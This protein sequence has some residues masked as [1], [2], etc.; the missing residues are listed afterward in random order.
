MPHHLINRIVIAVAHSNDHVALAVAHHDYTA[1]VQALT[2]SL[3][4]FK[5]H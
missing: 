2:T 5:S 4:A 3:F 1:L